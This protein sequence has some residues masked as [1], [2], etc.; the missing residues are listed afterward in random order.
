MRISIILEVFVFGD[1]ISFG[2]RNAKHDSI[3]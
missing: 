2:G 1:I 3:Y